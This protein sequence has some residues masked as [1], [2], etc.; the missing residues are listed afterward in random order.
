MTY[1]H[2]L[3]K[4]L[5]RFRAFT[6]FAVLVAACSDGTVQDYLGPEP[7]PTKTLVGLSI[8]PRDPQVAVGD[9]MRFEAMGW[10]SDGKSSPVPVAWSASGGSISSNGWFRPASVGDFRVRAS[11]VAKPGVSDSV[12]VAAINLLGGIARLEVSPAATAVPKGATQQFVARAIMQDGSTL[13]PTVS[14]TATGGSITPSGLFTATGDIGTATVTATLGAGMATGS[15]DIV[16]QPAILTQLL[17]NPSTVIMEV[18]E[19]RQ[20][21]VA[22]SWSDGGSAVPP[23]VW[24]LQGGTLSGG[25]QF[26]AGNAPGTYPLIISSPTFAKADTSLVWVLP[27]VV[28]I[29]VTP[30]VVT[31]APGAMQPLQAFAVR[32]DGSESPAGVQW[33]SSGGSIALDGRFTAG[34][35][36]GDYAVVGTL[37]ALS[38]ESFVDTARVAISDGSATITEISITPRSPAIASGDSVQFEPI[39]TWSDGTTAVP[40]VIWSTNGGEIDSTGVYTA[41]LTTGNF[42]VVGK[43]KGG[44]KADT[45]I[46]V[47]GPKLRTFRIKPKIDTIVSGS[48]LEYSATLTWS[49][50]QSH[51]YTITWST[52]GGVIS[53]TGRYTPGAL[54]GNFLVVAVC[55]CGAADTASVNVQNASP[56]APPTLTSLVLSPHAVALAL[57]GMQQFSASGQ[58]SDGSYGAVGVMYEVT[59]GNISASGFYVAGNTAGTYRVIA[60]QQGGTKA[61]TAIVTITAGPTLT[62]VVLNPAAV[63]VAPGATQQFGV[64]GLWSDG[65]STA[66]SVSYSAT[67]GTIS[68]SGVFTAD[69][70]P[71]TY[72]VVATALEAALADTAVVTVSG[73]GPT[74]TQ[75]VLNPSATTV[76]PGANKQFSV[77]ASW[78]DGSSALPP[79]SFTATGGTVSAGGLYTAGTIPGDYSVIVRHTGGTKAD[80]ST[81]TI[82]QL[83]S[84]SLNPASVSLGGGA[85]QL[86]SVAGTWSNGATTPPAVTYSATGGTVSPAGLYTAG[87]SIGTFRVIAVQTG[88]S[89]ADTSVVSITSAAPPPPPPSGGAPALPQLLNTTYVAP[90][91]Q[92]INVAAG[93]NLQSALNSAVCG[94]EILLAA[95][96]TYTGNFVLPA[97]Q[98]QSN[99]IH[100]RTAGALPPEGVR[101]TPTTAVGFAKL[102][103]ANTDAALKGAQGARGYRLVAL[104]ITVATGVTLNYG[105]L[106]IGEGNE[107]SL[108]Q[109]PGNV[110]IDRAY[111]HGNLA[112]NIQRCITLNGVA[113]AVIDSYVSECHAQGFEAQAAGGWNG[114][115]PFKIVNNYLEGAGENILFGGAPARISGVTPSDIEIRRNYFYKPLSWLGT[116]TVKNSFELKHAQRVLFEG[117]VLRYTW[118]NAQVGYIILLQSVEENSWA[119]VNDIT[120]RYNWIESSAS[121]INFLANGGG[122]A[123]NPNPNQ[124]PMSRILVEDNVIADMGRPGL[125]GEGKLLQL[126]NGSQGFR[127]LTIRH[128][129]FLH[130]TLSGAANGVSLMVDGSSTA[131]DRTSIQILDNLFSVTNYGV[132]GAGTGADATRTL[133]TFF[134]AGWD[135]RGNAFPAE[136]NKAS[137]P[138]GNYFPATLASLGMDATFK[139]PAGSPLSGKATDGKDIGADIP[140]LL[141]AIAGVDR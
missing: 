115:G 95:G 73:D 74:L 67:G 141:A 52:T 123:S 96:A 134:G 28:G 42:R 82:P 94:D 37:R 71:G 64:S 92:T 63:T 83:T 53:A 5:A 36:A 25:N 22:A 51:P 100:I 120:I 14:W 49:D 116:W 121:G 65:G 56:S 3:A 125:L 101:V 117:N 50:G 88:G 72:A 103:S 54:V 118:V 17:L 12:R 127:G 81:V 61:D 119:V 34:N 102:V 8:S 114:P 77:T 93:G 122:Y 86:F 138:A 4:R 20:L 62:Q 110:T 106:R 108:T 32:N 70:T 112:G 29:R 58:W 133:N 55:G 27:R 80:T 6:T 79:L 40:A 109:L 15:S 126:L 9:S 24:R 75:L 78:S 87:G 113:T 85:S 16:I 111:V 104:E 10:F 7:N 59:G 45:A 26:T 18:G 136:P 60:I 129:T 30:G 97:R 11:A 33:S 31:M 130:S 2:K 89:L 39:A 1:L 13:L 46:V 44:Q 135:F 57:G 68:S 35:T 19:T 43:Q 137:F 90:T 140:A 128:N 107:L 38:G 132:G 99:P 69:S 98:C 105:V 124:N 21:T 139:L 41:P 23:L 84:L 76:F 66:P 48:A 47:V 91:G 131:R